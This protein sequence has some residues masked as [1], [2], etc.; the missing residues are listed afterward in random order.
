[1]KTIEQINT[2]FDDKKIHEDI[3]K[4]RNFRIEIK[5]L[6]DQ[7]KT[8]G[9][10]EEVEDIKNKIST[11]TVKLEHIQ[12]DLDRKNKDYMKYLASLKDEREEFQNLVE[13]TIK[14]ELKLN[15]TFS[16]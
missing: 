8:A 5:T 13:D 1:E 10:F 9:L 11:N 4:F 6:E 15:I 14:E 12:S 3:E 7:I 2:I 16:F